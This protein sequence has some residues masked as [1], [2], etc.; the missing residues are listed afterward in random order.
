MPLLAFI[1]KPIRAMSAWSTGPARSLVAIATL[2]GLGACDSPVRPASQESQV[3][4]APF[5]VSNPVPAAAPSGSSAAAESAALSGPDEVYISLPPGAIPTG[6]TAEIRV[7]RTGSTLQV[8]L[9]GGGFDPVSL[10][11][12]AG[13]TLEVDVQLTDGSALSFVLTVALRVRPIVVRTDPPPHK[14]DVPLNA[15]LLVVFSEPI[16]AATLTSSSV[17][18]LT[19]GTTVAGDLA[20]TDSTHTKAQFVPSSPL[21]GETDYQLVVTQDVRDLDGDGLAAPTAVPFT[22]LG[23]GPSAAVGVAI[24]RVTA[25]G[26]HTCG[27]ALDGA[28]YCWGR[29]DNGQLGDGTTVTRTSPVLVAGGLPLIALFSGTA[30]TCGVTDWTVQGGLTYCWGLNSFG[31]IGDGTT[32]QRT[33]PGLVA[34]LEL[35]GIATGGDFS[36][37]MDDDFG[38]G[39]CW[40]ANDHGQLGNGTTSAARNP[41]RLTLPLCGDGPQIPGGLLPPN[42]ASCPLTGLR[43]GTSHIC[44][45]VR[46]LTNLVFDWYCWGANGNGQL[47]DGTT[48]DR[49]QVT[50]VG[51]GMSFGDLSAG[52]RHTCGT[53]AQYDRGPPWGV[54]FGAT[55]CWGLNT[56]GQLGDGTLTQRTSPVL[57]ASGQRF[58]PLSAGGAHTC[59]ITSGDL[60]CWGD[61]THGQLGNGSTVNSA[62]PLPVAGGLHFVSVSAGARHTCAV[63]AAGVAYCWGDNTFGQLGNGTTTDSRVPVKVRGQP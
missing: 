24:D 25:G 11:A 59:A 62:V 22:T 54:V 8:P 32:D 58:G 12:V 41:V 33:T 15:V 10:R 63:T 50:L 51:G 29:N 17:H 31:Q 9:L 30:H 16:N 5:V 26:N 61:N 47:G 48:I 3:T 20:F 55:Y 14:R 37:G 4:P 42:G 6:T 43:A 56:S 21:G 36:C 18:L 52:G 39:Y 46:G 1:K 40:G 23:C 7:H 13:D 35:D 34:V 60:F 49:A 44:A 57:V 45:Q 53:L 28:S 19:V 27:T 2:A 38:L